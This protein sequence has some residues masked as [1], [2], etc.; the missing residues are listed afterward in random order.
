MGTRE[1]D[2]FYLV[3]TVVRFLAKNAETG[4][5]C[6][7]EA[8]VAPGAGAPPNRHAGEDEAFYVLEG[9]FDFTIGE[10]TRRV[11]PGDFVKIPDG[12]LHAFTNTGDAPGRLLIM[13][14]PGLVHERFF[15]E[16]GEPLPPGSRDLPAS[17]APPDIPRL[18]EAGARAGI[19]FPRPGG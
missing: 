17:P 19:A 16:A 1:T 14:A 18:L 5:Y 9:S 6:L 13:N 4:G 15:S 2:S 10:D 8:T 7:C 3:G 11:G 12:A